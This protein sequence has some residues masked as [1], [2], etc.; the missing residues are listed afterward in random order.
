MGSSAYTC[1]KR[2]GQAKRMAKSEI[3]FDFLLSK[4]S[5]THNL[6]LKPKIAVKSEKGAC[7]KKRELHGGVSLARGLNSHMEELY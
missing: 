3:D 7:L 1:P 2:S 6:S 4:P 5:H